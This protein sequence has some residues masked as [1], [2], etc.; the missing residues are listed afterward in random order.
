DAESPGPLGAARGP[1][2]TW[3]QAPSYC[4]ADEATEEAD[5][6]AQEDLELREQVKHFVQETTVAGRVVDVVM[7]E[8]R[9][10]V[11][12]LRLTRNLRFFQLEVGGA[13]HEIPVTT[14]KDVCTGV[15]V[16]SSWAPV[17]LDGLCSTIVLKNE[18]CL[19][20]RFDSDAE[21]D[22][23][24]RCVRIMSMALDL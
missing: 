24:S 7:E 20:F 15:D 17:R 5:F 9:V 16:G 8:G 18:E 1:A 23:F 19:T 13:V 14:V 12:C 21:R 10:E 3:P 11:G 6:G 22:A 2:A 4:T